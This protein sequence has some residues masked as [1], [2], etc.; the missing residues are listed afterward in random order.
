MKPFVPYLPVVALI[1]V[2]LL[3]GM[4]TSWLGQDVHW[5]GYISMLVFYV[6]IFGAGIWASRW[7]KDGTADGMMLAGRSMPLWMAIFTMSATWVGGGYINGSAEYAAS[8]GITWVQAPWGYALSL[9]IG[10]LFFARKMRRLEFSTMLD[11]LGRRYGGRMAALFFLPALAGEIFWTAA[12]LTAL[13]TTFGTVLGMDFGPSILIS[14]AI[15]LVY[16]SLGGLWSVALTDV[17][18]LILLF[19]GLGLVI[20]FALSQTGGWEEVWTAYEAK[21]GVFTHIFPPWNGWQ[22]PDW[23]DYYWNWWDTALLLIFGGIPWQVYFQRVLSA[24][25]PQTAMWL[26]ILA[27]VVCIL[28][29]LPAMAIGVIGDVADW[30]AVGAP[31]PTDAALILPW[32]VRYLTPPV[33]AT[34]GLGAIAAAVMSSVDSSILS[35]S[36]MAGW[37]VFRPWVRPKITDAELIKVIRR[38]I[39]IIGI[40]ATLLALQIKSVYVLWFLCSDFVYTLLFP[41]LVA[42]LFD[43]KANR[44]GALAGF[45]VALLLRWGGGEAQLGIDAW[46]PY[47]MQT[48]DGIVLFPFR[49]L[50]M[51]SGLLTIFV[52]SRL[53]QNQSPTIPLERKN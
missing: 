46:L 39:W 24:K 44:I 33:V 2:F 36:S 25:S 1:I 11:P 18:Q 12:I 7:K 6:L 22:H 26:S 20:P 29:A 41:A 31:E 19:V 34:L 45:M 49:T 53:T 30:Q 27:G 40:T 16:T 48:S 52:V 17:I 51:L 21:K 43:P 13:G 8:F 42:A 15:A 4:I 37:N 9:I 38:C 35:A 23:G 3:T 14:A 10:G 32:V 47:P 28:A 50:A 5:P